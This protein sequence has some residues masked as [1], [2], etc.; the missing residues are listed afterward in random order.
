MT[1]KRN[2]LFIKQFAIATQKI[3]QQQWYKIYTSAHGCRTLVKTS[4]MPRTFPA[5]ADNRATRSYSDVIGVSYT[6]IL[7]WPQKKKYQYVKSGSPVTKKRVHHV[8]SSARRRQCPDDSWCSCWSEL[9]LH[10]AG[11]AFVYEQLEKCSGKTS[12]RTMPYLWPF[13]RLGRK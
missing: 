10:C 9:G 7:M 2:N 3:D 5:A 6:L 1:K 8:L 4:V 13:K 12:S 11:T